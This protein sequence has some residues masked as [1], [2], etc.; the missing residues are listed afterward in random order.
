MTV[1]VVIVM[2]SALDVL[3]KEP[4]TQIPMAPAEDFLLS[5]RN[6]ILR[7]SSSSKELIEPAPPNHA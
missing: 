7:A 3:V 1:V 5:D 6:N 2:A 4:E